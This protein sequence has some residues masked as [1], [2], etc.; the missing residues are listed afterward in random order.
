MRAMADGMVALAA[1]ILYGA[2]T[3]AEA[4]YRA[5]KAHLPDAVGVGQVVGVLLGLLGLGMISF[6]LGERA[7][8]EQAQTHG[9]APPSPPTSS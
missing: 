4:V 5:G 1:A 2:S 7:R 8:P 9:E 3:L 6:G